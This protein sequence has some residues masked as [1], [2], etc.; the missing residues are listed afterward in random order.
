MKSKLSLIGVAL[1]AAGAMLAQSAQTP[2]AS[3]TNSS[4]PPVQTRPR[5]SYRWQ[6]RVV[7]RLT[8]RLNL[9]SDQQSQVKEILRNSRSEM[10]TWAPQFREERMA[11]DA[12]VKADSLGQID[13][14]AQQNMNLNSKMEANHLKTVAK[15]YAI[16]TPD[17]KV[18]FDQNF[19]RM[20]G[21]RPAAPSTNKG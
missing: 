16:L 1:C 21:L 20:M 13:Q 8:S 10:K 9:T 17:Q 2:A 12:A 5:Q 11:L 18:K 14:I 15:I 6:D 19:D 3:S 4:Q 7:R